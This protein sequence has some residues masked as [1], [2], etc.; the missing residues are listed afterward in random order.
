MSVFLSKSTTFAPVMRVCALIAIILLA[1]FASPVAFA[2]E[3]ACRAREI[4][5]AEAAQPDSIRVSLLTCSPGRELYSLYGHTAIR[6]VDY[7]RGQDVVFNYGVFSFSQPHFI[8]RFV[9]GKCDYMVDAVPFGAFLGSYEQRGSRVTEQVL[10]LTSEEAGRVMAYLTENCLPENCR[11]RYNFL[12]NNCTTMVRDVI[13]RCV[14][15]E[16]IY[17]ARTP[18]QTTREI[19]HHYTQGHPW[20][21]EGDDF[22]LGSAVDTLASD[23]AAMFA[24]EYMM[25]YAAT[26]AIRGE[27]G[28]ERPLVAATVVLTPG[29]E[30][31]AEPEFPLSPRQV[32][33]GLLALAVLVML[34][35]VFSGRT[36]VPWSVL[37]LLAQ[38][39]VGSL[40]LFMFLFSEHP[41]VDSNWL[42]W[43]F[44]PIALPGL[45]FVVCGSR[46]AKA[47][48]WVAYFCFLALFLVFYP[49][50]P[51]EFGNIVVPL[52]MCLLTRPVEFY[53]SSRRKGK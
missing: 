39:L 7:V 10:S 32:G 37:L 17:S 25:E 36:F 20:A 42:L 5:V 48:W 45:Y 1:C 28:R 15:G 41:A 3:P 4:P 12:Y 19:I 46:V 9:L 40:L 18:R 27:D 53:L 51:Q 43:P 11:Y 21:A 24:P 14:Q 35:E 16:I 22:L 6:C 38:G 44:S 33:W 23:R 52:T 8:W 30:V 13:E 26:A 29:R 34:V 2:Q 31:P 47:R 49:L 50:I